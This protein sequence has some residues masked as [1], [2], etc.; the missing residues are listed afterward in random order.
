MRTWNNQQIELPNGKHTVQDWWDEILDGV[1]EG[2]KV[3]NGVGTLFICTSTTEHFAKKTNRIVRLH[4]AKKDETP[5]KGYKSE[6]WLFTEYE[7][8]ENT[9]PE[10]KQMR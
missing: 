7:N 6:M 2:D 8:Y 3:L 5:N 10:W 4:I 1:E 9:C